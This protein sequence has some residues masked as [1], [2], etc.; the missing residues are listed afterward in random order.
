MEALGN[1]YQKLDVIEE[2]IDFLIRGQEQ[3]L[4]NQQQVF[5]ALKTISKQIDQNQNELREK[6]E[7]VHKDIIYNRQLLNN[8]VITKYTNCYRMIVSDPTRTMPDTLINT[9]M[10]KFPTYNELSNL[11]DKWSSNGDINGCFDIIS[12]VRKLDGTF[13]NPIFNLKS[14]ED[15]NNYKWVQL[16][17]ENV[18]EPLIKYI[19]QDTSLSELSINQKRTSLFVPSTSAKG[20]DTKIQ[21]IKILKLDLSSRYASSSFPNSFQLNIA[22]PLWFEAVERHINTI[23]NIHYYRMVINRT[24]NRPYSVNK[25]LRS[26]INSV[27]YED[28]K[29]GLDLIDFAISQQNL[30]S[31]DILLPILGAIFDNHDSLNLKKTEE[32]YTLLNSNSLL[33]TNFLMY[34]L[35]KEVLANSNFINYE[36]GYKSHDKFMLSLNFKNNWNFEWNDSTEIL[37]SHIRPKGWSIKIGNQYYLAPSPVDLQEGKLAYSQDIQRLINLKTRLLEEIDTYEIYNSL[38][39]E[40][41]KSFNILTLFLLPEESN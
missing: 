16:F 13:D 34:K 3:I 6:L 12:Q 23:L 5:E 35:R 9:E 40:E 19:E 25:L 18:H 39:Q 41:R 31:G 37:E 26:D 21:Q 10:N 27:G 38:T 20:L 32:L 17:I 28:L 29:N 30:Y 7:S 36:L 1:I 15:P 24:T 4:K 14:S 2:K 33:A 11:C 22:T 8:Y